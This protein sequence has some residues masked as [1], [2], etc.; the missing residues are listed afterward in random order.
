MT[1]FKLVAG[2]VVALSL[3]AC[4]TAPTPTGSV[5]VPAPPSSPAAPAEVR[6]PLTLLVSI[7]GFHPS[8]L[9]RGVTPHLNQLIK[10]GVYG[11]MRP[12]FPSKTFPNH[13]TI[14]TGKRPNNHGIV[15]NNMRDPARPGPGENFSLGNTR[16]A[17][18]PFWWSQAEPVWVTAEKQG[19]R[20]ATMFWPGSEVAIHGGRPQDWE[21]FDQNVSNTQRANAVID[22]VRRP[23]NLRPKLITV[24]FDTVD[25]A[26]HKFGPAAAE[27]TK[28][29]ADVDTQIG[30]IVDSIKALHQPVNII[31]TSDHGM[32]AT[33][34]DRLIDLDK[35][36]TR[37]NYQLVG[38]G[39]FA[40][41]N[42]LPGKDAIVEAAL[43]KPATPHANMTCWNKK[44]IPAQ[45]QY[46]SN[47]RIPAIFCL[48]NMGWKVVMGKPEY[49]ANGGDHGYDNFSP[50]MQAIFIANGP[51]ILKGKTLPVF[52]NVDVYPLIAYLI[53]MQPL[54]Y[55]GVPHLPADIRNGPAIV[56][57]TTGTKP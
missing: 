55:D 39:P 25:T 43:V 29:V 35:L 17:L 22:W 53:G 16:Q 56:P 33:S 18:D 42:P 24:Y 41:L 1:R 32:A 19:I 13:Y 37:D 14:V 8:Y 52:D 12:S 26:G 23:A 44:D 28:A 6:A 40:T 31:V 20:T 45:Y 10:T 51:E 21:R 30:Y 38:S 48:A 5:G 2:A 34:N 47:P 36:L 46:G 3:S 50:E 4:E 49:D 7:D 57:A 11:P 27:T 15:D 9:Q 54:P